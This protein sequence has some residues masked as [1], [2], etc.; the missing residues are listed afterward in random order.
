MTKVKAKRFKCKRS[1]A[2]YN[3]LYSPLDSPGYNLS[4][5]AFVYVLSISSVNY[6]LNAKSI[7]SD[8]TPR[9]AAFELGLH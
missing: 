3:L 9:F 8:E 2:S 7:Y 5:F 1:F 6:A 4:V